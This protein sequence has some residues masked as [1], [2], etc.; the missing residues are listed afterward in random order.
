MKRSD[1]RVTTSLVAF[2]EMPDKAAIFPFAIHDIQ[3]VK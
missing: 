1:P 2:S 3:G